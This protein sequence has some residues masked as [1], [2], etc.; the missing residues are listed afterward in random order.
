MARYLKFLQIV[1]M[2]AYG[3]LKDYQMK[4]LRL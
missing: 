2:L 1:K 4:K 3:D